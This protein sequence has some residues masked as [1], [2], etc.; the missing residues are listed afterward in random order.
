MFQVFALTV[1]GTTLSVVLLSVAGIFAMLSFTVAQRRREIG[2]RA[3]LGANPRQL[4]GGIFR[5]AAAQLG[6]GVAVGLVVA[7]ALERITDGMILGSSAAGVGLRG[8]VVLMPIVAA[9]VMAVGLM[10]ALGPVRRA[11]AVHPT[12]ALRDG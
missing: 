2:V 8:S 9:I 3:A 1:A 11:L 4:V 5:R 10:A 7:L 6:M 12:E